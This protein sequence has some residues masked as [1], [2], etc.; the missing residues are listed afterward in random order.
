MQRFAPELPS[1][2]YSRVR[3][4][5]RVSTLAKLIKRRALYFAIGAFVLA[6]SS[7]SL[8]M[9]KTLRPNGSLA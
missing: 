1:L 6:A 7:S 4:L 2:H 9:W 5:W 3:F 8:L